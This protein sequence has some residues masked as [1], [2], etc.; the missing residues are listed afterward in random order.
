MRMSGL[1]D[2]AL[3][4]YFLLGDDIVIYHDDVARNY[5]E[6]VTNLGVEIS[7]LKT[8]KSKCFFEFAKR[9]FYYREEISPFPVA[10][11]KTAD[12]NYFEVVETFHNAMEKG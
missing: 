9:Y 1:T 12:K 4:P 5:L 11:L 3:A 2:M 7:P 8:H 6:L 10:S